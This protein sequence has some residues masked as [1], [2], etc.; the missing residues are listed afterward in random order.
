MTFIS[1][2]VLKK[3]PIT[4]YFTQAV[5]SWKELY[6]PYQFPKQLWWQN[7]DFNLLLLF[8]KVVLKCSW[9]E[10]SM[11][12]PLLRNLAHTFQKQTSR[13]SEILTAQSL[14]STHPGSLSFSLTSREPCPF[15]LMAQL[16]LKTAPGVFW[17]HGMTIFPMILLPRMGKC[18]QLRLLLRRYI[19]NLAWNVSN[20]NL[21]VY[22]TN[23]KKDLRNNVETSNPKS[24]FCSFII[25]ARIFLPLSS[26]FLFLFLFTMHCRSLLK[27]VEQK[28]QQNFFY[29]YFIRNK[30]LTSER[31]STVKL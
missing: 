26:H 12:S 7:S 23:S 9:R 8:T 18:S 13:W 2:V 29:L 15:H 25:E 31:F 10:D 19:I 20:R 27:N 14:P 3:F 17:E 6:V 24:R 16:S 11:T 28:R 4:I 30:F 1:L 21:K 22:E 5:N